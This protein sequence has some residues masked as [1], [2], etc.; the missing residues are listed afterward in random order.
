MRRCAT[1]GGSW[2]ASGGYR[3][4]GLCAVPKCAVYAGRCYVRGLGAGL[5]WCVWRDVA[6][7]RWAVTMSGLGVFVCVARYS[8]AVCGVTWRCS[9]AGLCADPRWAD[10]MP[11]DFMFVCVARYSHAVCGVTW[12]FS[13]IHI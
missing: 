13:R 12:R 7:L 9:R 10:P 2:G 6:L 11:C 3:G 4:R 8:H 5:M 1:H